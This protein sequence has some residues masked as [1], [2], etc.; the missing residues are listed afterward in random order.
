[1]TTTTTEAR[2][3]ILTRPSPLTIAA[4]TTGAVPFVIHAWMALAGY[5]GHDDFMV[6]YL[7]AQHG[8]FDPG[9]LFQ[10]YNG[11]IEPGKFAV[12]WLVTALAPLNH[13]LAV[14]PLLAVQA[15]ASILLWRVLTRIFGP[16]WTVLVPFAVYALCPLVLYPT[17]W[18]AYG[19]EL[20][21]LLLAMF[22]AINAHLTYLRTRATKHLVATLV[23]TVAGM[24]FYEK[25]ALFG[26][27]LFGITL[28]LGERVSWRIWLAHVG[29][30]AGYAVLYISLVTSR[31]ESTL[32]NTDS[33]VDFARRAVVDTLLPSLFGGPW[34]DPGPGTSG[35]ITTPPLGLRLAVV[36]L[37]AVVVA[38]GLRRAGK[39]AAL[40]WLLLAAYLAVD[41]ALVIVTRLPEIGP[42]IGTD[43]R[44]IADVVPVAVLCGTFAY[45][46]PGTRTGG[47]LSRPVVLTVVTLLGIS[48]TFSFLQLAPGLRFDRSRQYV[49][50][51]QAALAASPSMVLYDVPVPPEIMV[52]WFGDNARSSRVIGL[53]PERPRFDQ[54]TDEMYLL[55][56]NGSPRRIT[57][58]RDPVVG[59]TG[60]LDKCG[61]P[62]GGQIVTIPL[63]G[64]VAGR[65]LLRMEYYTTGA[66]PVRIAL[67]DQVREVNFSQGL[68]ELYVVVT[69]EGDRLELNRTT[70]VDPI[71]VVD[72]RIGSPLVE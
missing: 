62:V 32:P 15:A 67:G 12:A 53:L 56:A 14:L 16:P 54:P 38:G 50:T 34:T 6:L 45:L 17:L 21:P 25:A 29:V 7:A 42:L 10:D 2:Q 51:A 64:R 9:Y 61:Y 19:M 46:G 18:W 68:H 13:V 22:G 20:L 48:A 28:L 41:L 30:L 3:I 4:V 59:R 72:V 65:Q 39:R 33:V 49:A 24:A 52:E 55:D 8:P 31:V 57:G 63:S 44:Y 1:M 71:C 11:H 5:F 27:V 60:P 66:G 26:A 58:V 43:P 36:V 37:V 70:A 40:A 47:G 69:G 35:T 23:W